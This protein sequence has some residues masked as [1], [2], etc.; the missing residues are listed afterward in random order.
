MKR[1]L[2]AFALAAILQNPA[3]A[4]AQSWPSRQITL[5]VPYAVGGPVDTVARIVSLRMSEDSGSADHR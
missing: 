3:G 4:L 1:N 5:V 2:V